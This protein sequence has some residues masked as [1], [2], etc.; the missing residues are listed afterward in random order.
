M[1]QSSQTDTPV[2]PPSDLLSKEPQLE[3]YRHL[4]QLILLL[5]CLERLWQNRQ[6]FFAGGNI[7]IYY[8][9]RQLKSEDVKGP[10]FF[11]V[12]NTERREHKSW[13]VWEEDGKYPNFILEILSESTAKNDRGLKKQLYQDVF[14]TP[15][16]F[17]FDPYT[18]ELAGFKL[19]Y[20]IYEPIVANEQGWLWSDELQLY[21]GIVGEQ[22]RFFT[23]DGELVL[24]PE[25]AEAEERQRA[26]TERQRADAAEAKV[27]TLR[28]KLLELG[29]NLE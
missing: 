17:W 13:I 29:V 1:V 22:L 5:T 6:D 11:V 21:L 27:E 18:L 7:S 10:D 23:P 14:R 15:D 25:E 19:N 20:R 4:K 2:F 12:L 24:T 3:T 28:Q 16:Y 8:S 9:I 26:E